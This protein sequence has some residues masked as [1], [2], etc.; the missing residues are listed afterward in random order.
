MCL[1]T[2]SSSSG[3]GALVCLTR[4]ALGSAFEETPFQLREGVRT[5]D[6]RRT[7]PAQHLAL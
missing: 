6:P 2:G 4:N 5:P 1:E 7:R 3:T